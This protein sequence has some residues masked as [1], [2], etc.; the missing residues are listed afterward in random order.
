LVLFAEAINNNRFAAIIKQKSNPH[1]Q[2]RPFMHLKG[3]T[4]TLVTNHLSARKQAYENRANTNST[5]EPLL[6][7]V[8]DGGS[9]GGRIGFD[10]GL[11]AIFVRSRTTTSAGTVVAG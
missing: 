5:N 11:I 6:E 9:D 1:P 4:L 10:D 7:R 3:Y 2:A 8:G